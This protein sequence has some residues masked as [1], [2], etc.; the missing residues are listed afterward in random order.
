[1]SA[2]RHE[3]HELLTIENVKVI[4]DVWDN[5][6][7]DLYIGD[8]P[9]TPANLIEIVAFVERHGQIVVSTDGGVSTDV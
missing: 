3:H 1:M 9:L 6:D 4:V 7:V 8:S 5:G 2:S